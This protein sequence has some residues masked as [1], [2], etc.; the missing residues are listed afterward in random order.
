M[1]LSDILPEESPEVV[2]LEEPLSEDIAPVC[3][4]VIR[5]KAISVTE[6]E[7]SEGEASI[8]ETVIIIPDED[9]EYVATRTENDDEPLAAHEGL[10]RTA[11][12]CEMIDAAAALAGLKR[13]EPEK[14]TRAPI[15]EPCRSSKRF[16]TQTVFYIQ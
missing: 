10:L 4:V 11:S 6:D 16:R 7:W 1:K 12:A 5:G 3:E 9:E 15:A 13:V 8:P 2:L 14:P